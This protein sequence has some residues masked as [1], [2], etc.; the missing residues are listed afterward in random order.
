MLSFSGSLRVFVAVEDE[1]GLLSVLSRVLQ[2]YH[3]RV[4]TAGSAAEA[5]RVWD[6]HAGQVDVLL[7]DMIMPGEWTGNDLVNELRKRK[8]EQFDG[9]HRWAPAKGLKNR[10]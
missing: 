1:A 8:P 6:K 3:Y 4:L 5:L 9:N 7:T 2:R 10:F